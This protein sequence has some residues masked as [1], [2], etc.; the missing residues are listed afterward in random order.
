MHEIGQP[1]S[2]GSDGTEVEAK[3]NGSLLH[4][5]GLWHHRLASEPGCLAVCQPSLA[6]QK[7]HTKTLLSLAHIS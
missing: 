3:R 2:W 4:D 1:P 7:A 5:N 6:A